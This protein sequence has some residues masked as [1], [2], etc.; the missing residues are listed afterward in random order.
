MKKILLALLCLGGSVYSFSQTAYS[1]S[2]VMI[3]DE[4]AKVEEK[5]RKDNQIIP[6]HLAGGLIMVDSEINGVASSC[7]FDTGAPT[8]IINKEENLIIQ[9]DR[10]GVGV[11]GKKKMKTIV[12]NDFEMGNLKK[13]NIKALEVDISH[14]EKLKKE[15]I[16]GILGVDVYKE[17]EVLIDYKKEEIRL[18]PRK[19]KKNLE[20]KKKI[21]SV[22]FFM[23]KQLPVIK[24]KIGKK[25][26]YFGVDTGAEVNVIDK[27]CMKKLKKCKMKAGGTQLMAGVSEHKNQVKTVTID[28]FRIKN[29]HFNKCDFVFMDLT[30]FK[31]NHGFPIDGILG[32]PFLKENLISFDFRRSKLNFWEEKIER[33]ERV[34]MRE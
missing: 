13:E 20:T 6:F 34:A 11:T 1:V 33:E 24:V 3:F 5:Q 17:Q 15:V 29:Q 28:Q 12:V 32:F 18:L 19:R 22:S 26:F 10:F 16:D 14:I 9:P 8:I 4:Q 23:E 2:N 21:A 31:K 25:N 27:R 30:Q 7:I